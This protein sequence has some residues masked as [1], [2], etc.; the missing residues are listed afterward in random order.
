MG[1]KCNP[2]KLESLN[3]GKLSKTLLLYENDLSLENVKNCFPS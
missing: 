2:E 1:Q 3:F